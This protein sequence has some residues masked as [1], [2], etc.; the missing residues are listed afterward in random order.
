MN[1]PRHP[2]Q[3]DEPTPT[4]QPM[5]TQTKI[6]IALVALMIILHIAGIAPH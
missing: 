4:K 2:D 6:I 3:R 1:I 5:R